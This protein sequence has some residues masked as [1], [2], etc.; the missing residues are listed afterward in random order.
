MLV[1]TCASIFMVIQYGT[2]SPLPL[3][4]FIKIVADVLI[5]LLWYNL[6]EQQLYYYYNLGIRK[7]LLFAFT[8]G[9]DLFSFASIHLIL[10]VWL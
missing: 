6:R 7:R 1:L 10:S 4:F 9:F 2:L 5:F 3:F 8:M